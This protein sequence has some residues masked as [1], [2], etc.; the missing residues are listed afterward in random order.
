LKLID[1][2]GKDGM[3]LAYYIINYITKSHHIYF[4]YVFIITKCGLKIGNNL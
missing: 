3:A 4:T 2:L 1:A